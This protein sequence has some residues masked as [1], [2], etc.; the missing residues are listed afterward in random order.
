MI[1]GQSYH[2]TGATSAEF[3]PFFDEIVN[4]GKPIRVQFVLG[5]WNKTIVH[6]G[7]FIR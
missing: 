4:G 2:S 1:D 7:I 5:K 6:K 3:E